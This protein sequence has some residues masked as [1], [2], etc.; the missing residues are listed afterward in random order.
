MVVMV[1]L[2]VAADQALANN[3]DKVVEKQKSRA[4][5]RLAGQAIQTAVIARA[6]GRRSF[7]V[8]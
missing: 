4:S 5:A 3:A 1:D 6:P 2:P 8:G 7:G